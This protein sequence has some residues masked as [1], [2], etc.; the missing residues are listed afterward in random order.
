MGDKV[1]NAHA[2]P[3]EAYGLRLVDELTGPSGN[4]GFGWGKQRNNVTAIGRHE[5]SLY[6]SRNI[7]GKPLVI[8]L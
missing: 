7:R 3:S 1:A 2:R 4:M 6:A 5:N 8:M